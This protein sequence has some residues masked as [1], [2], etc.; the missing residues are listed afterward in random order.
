MHISRQAY[1]G[2][3]ESDLQISA[4]A[5]AIDIQQGMLSA[6]L[7][8]E[9]RQGRRIAGQGYGRWTDTCHAPFPNRQVNRISAPGYR[10]C[11]TNVASTQNPC[12]RHMCSDKLYP[13]P[14]TTQSR[15]MQDKAGSGWPD[16][17]KGAWTKAHSHTGTPVRVDRSTQ[18]TS[19]H[20]HFRLDH[21]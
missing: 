7:R 3:P 8:T 12:T 17:P 1:S 14:P 20:P 6:S 10:T 9:I 5:P 19:S 21:L 13:Y 16:W 2:P 18:S 15:E 11:M 4:K